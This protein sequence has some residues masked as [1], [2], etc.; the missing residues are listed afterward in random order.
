MVGTRISTRRSRAERRRMVATGLFEINGGVNDAG[1]NWPDELSTSGN[2]SGSLHQKRG[3]DDSRKISVLRHGDAPTHRS[4]SS[5]RDDR[6]RT[7]DQIGRQSVAPG[8][9]RG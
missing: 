1:G 2:A 3:M 6:G 5:H 7:P 4:N 8:Q 9:R